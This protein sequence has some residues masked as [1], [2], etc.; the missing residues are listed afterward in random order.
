MKNNHI[1]IVL[2][3]SCLLS[4]II[5]FININNGSIMAK[6]INNLKIQNNDIYSYIAHAGGGYKEKTYSN[7]KE[8]LL[9][10]IQSGYKLIELDL[11]VTADKYIF[12]SH[13]LNFY[14]NICGTKIL[15]IKDLY[16]KDIKSCNLKNNSI[17]SILTEVEINKIFL[18]NKELILITD[19]IRDYKLLKTKFKFKNRII[20]ETFSVSDYL[21][22]KYIG[23]KNPMYYYNGRK[24]NKFFI[25]IFRPKIISTPI[26]LVQDQNIFLKKFFKKKNLILAYTS[27]DKNFNERYLNKSI[28]AVYTD[29]WDINNSKC[30]LINIKPKL[31]DK[32]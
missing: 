4:L 14:N 25:E 8:A 30:Y 24:I 21:Y 19:K 10:S 17:F 12:A 1:R 29:F 16:L 9:N 27:N 2:I 31:C 32:Y 15:S 23:I 11:M 26:N 6:N 3:I 5:F 20:V 28:S 18:K 22:A 7:S 13:D